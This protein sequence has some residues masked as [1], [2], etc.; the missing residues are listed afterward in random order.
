MSTQNTQANQEGVLDVALTNEPKLI[1]VTAG[2]K[3]GETLPSDE[4]ILLF[5][6][7]I[8]YGRKIHSFAK[9]DSFFQN[10]EL[11]DASFFYK[12][13][14]HF[15]RETDQ[16]ESQNVI[17]WKKGECKF[18][19]KGTFSNK[20]V[21]RMYTHE[22]IDGEICTSSDE[23]CSLH[24]GEIFFYED[25]EELGIVETESGEY[26]YENDCSLVV[27]GRWGQEE[28]AID[29]DNEYVYHDGT[30]Y[31]NDSVASENGVQYYSRFDEYMTEDEYMERMGEESDDGYDEHHNTPSYHHFTPRAVR[32]ENNKGDFNFGLEI[33]KVD[34]EVKVQ[35]NAHQLHQDIKWCKEQDASL[36]D[37]NGLNYKGFEVVTP[38]YS[39]FGNLWKK[40]FEKEDVTKILNAQF[41]KKCGG[42]F[43]LSST[44]YSPDELFE[45]LSPFFPLLYS[46]YESRIHEGYCYAF[47][48]DKMSYSPE[49]RT[50]IYKQSNRIEFRIF[51]AVRSKENAIWRIDLVKIFVKN[52]N[53]S[54]IDVLKM[55]V[56]EKSPLHKHLLKVYTK[57]EINGKIFKYIRYAREFNN[58]NLDAPKRKESKK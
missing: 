48:K 31:L 30:T 27:T 19:T 4:V 52:I 15:I 49:K 2:F 5:S 54:E 24:T 45:G 7:N 22:M 23:F 32:I 12:H 47:K 16:L 51:P 13:R 57:E 21:L 37:E 42:H 33:E 39:L 28:W 56:N 1:K 46:M 9:D 36:R 38:V 26:A 55:M 41:N 44:K 53:C 18:V 50:A 11:V 58:K 14:D 17:F 34:R 6:Q 35:V 25:M 8:D 40:D 29:C 3:Y 10:E 43:N 20:W